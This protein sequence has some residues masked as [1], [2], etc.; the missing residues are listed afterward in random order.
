[1][2]LCEKY[3]H[4][5]FSPKDTLCY[6]PIQNF[7]FRKISSSRPKTRPERFRSEPRLERMRPEHGTERCRLE[8]RRPKPRPKKV[9]AWT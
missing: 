3:Q 7:G 6:R 9:Q 5:T 8:K 1:M 4:F 2:I